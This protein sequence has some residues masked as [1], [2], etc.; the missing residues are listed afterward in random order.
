MESRPRMTLMSRSMLVTREGLTW[1][2]EQRWW[3]TSLGRLGFFPMNFVARRQA[4][5]TLKLLLPFPFILLLA[6]LFLYL[7]GSQGSFHEELTR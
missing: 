7:V 1:S 4:S 2:S 5:K 3:K 6:Q